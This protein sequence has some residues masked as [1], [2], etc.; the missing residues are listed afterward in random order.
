MNREDVPGAILKLA[1]R[2]AAGRDNDPDHRELADP[3]NDAE[4]EARQIRAAT[5]RPEAIKFAE[6]L[7]AAVAYARNKLWPKPAPPSDNMA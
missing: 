7:E 4:D 5:S 3:V 6:R 1:A 2:A